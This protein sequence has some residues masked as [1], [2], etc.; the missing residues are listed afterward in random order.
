MRE[1]YIAMRP[2]Y[3]VTSE[4]IDGVVVN[5]YYPPHLEDGGQ[6]ALRYAADS[7]HVFNERFGP[8]PY[9]EF[10][11]IATPTT[12]GGIEYPG[13]V[14][15]N[16]QLY[17]FKGAFFQQT[18]AHEVAHQWWYG[19]VGND[20]VDEPW[21][22]EAL[23]NYSTVLY[24]EEVAGAEMADKIIKGYFLDPY[25]KARENNEDRSVVG[26]VGDF[27]EREYSIFVYGKGPLFFNAL[28]QEVGD[29]VYLDIMQ[30]YYA[31]YKYKIAD[32]NDL[33]TLIERVS[34]QDI[35]PLFEKWLQ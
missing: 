2:D 11:V 18:V 8:Y 6:A 24:W 21:L 10:D 5:S 19:V 26:S 35:D 7:L 3:A 30:T 23:T 27:S 16:Q 31:Q 34:G 29:D 13:I 17:E 12:A 28:R 14:V 25:Q 15:V 22:D 32:A 20:Q 9:A 1:F 4:T 33:L